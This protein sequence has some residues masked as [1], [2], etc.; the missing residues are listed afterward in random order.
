MA[1]R[2]T[3]NQKR[4]SMWLQKPRVD[5]TRQHGLLSRIPSVLQ[6]QL[7]SNHAADII[8]PQGNRCVN[9]ELIEIRTHDTSGYKTAVY[10]TFDNLI[11]KIYKLKQPTLTTQQLKIIQK[12]K[13]TKKKDRRPTA[14]NARNFNSIKSSW[15]K[16]TSKSHSRATPTPLSHF[17]P[18]R[19]PTKAQHQPVVR[20]K[21]LH[22]YTDTNTHK[23]TG[24]DT[25][26]TLSWAFWL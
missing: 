1:T 21:K 2:R 25:R 6:C 24:W 23:H 7:W 14:C 8:S 4:E 12:G 17:G 20:V 5:R 16:C 13:H 26:Q 19:G 18:S 11:K 9:L 3:S 22:T 10:R 15:P